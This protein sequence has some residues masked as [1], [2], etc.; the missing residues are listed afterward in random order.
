MS[1]RFFNQRRIFLLVLAALVLASLLK[2]AGA[3]MISGTPRHI[4]EKIVGIVSGPLKS[5]SDSVRRRPD[6]QLDRGNPA[7]LAQNYDQLKRE[8]D[9]LFQ[10]KEALKRELDLLRRFRKLSGQESI[11]LVRS[12][13]T[14]WRSD[15]QRQTLTINR[16]ALQGLRPGLAVVDWY[17]FSLVGR[18][19]D[20]GPGTATVELITSATTRVSVRFKPFGGARLPFVPPVFQLDPAD[21]QGRFSKVIKADNPDLVKPGYVAFLYL[22]LNQDDSIW[23]REAA[24]FAVGK[25]TAVE[26][27]AENPLLYRRVVVEPIHSLA[28]LGQVMVLV[29]LTSPPDILPPAISPPH[30]SSSERSR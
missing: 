6:Q 4:V 22:S 12:D 10:E 19:T 15:A 14:A 25:V 27:W 5:L 2:P 20:V 21:R 9:G 30:G 16:G 7:L 18:L 13:V 3:R 17:D 1:L 24:G 23:P 29:P 11:D 8:N 28:H 26:P